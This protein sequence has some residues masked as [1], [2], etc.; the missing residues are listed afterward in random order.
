MSDQ[1]VLISYSKD[2]G[3]TWTHERKFLLPPGVDGNYLRRVRFQRI[4]SCQQIIFRLRHSDNG[5]FS[6]IEGHADVQVGI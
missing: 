2:G 6:I 1:Y 4:G 5:P 3:H